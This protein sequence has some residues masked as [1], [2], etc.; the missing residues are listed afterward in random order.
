V[1]RRPGAP[2]H[3][4]TTSWAH[5]EPQ[6]HTGEWR[7]ARSWSGAVTIPGRD[8]R[9]LPRLQRQQ[10]ACPSSP[11]T[12]SRSRCPT[13]DALVKGNEVRIGGVPGRHR[14]VRGA[15]PGERRPRRRRTLAQ[16]RQERRTAAGR[17]D[18]DDPAEVGAGA[19]V[20]AGDA[21]QTPPRALPPAKRSHSPPTRR[22]R[23]TS[24]NS[25]TC[26]DEPTRLAIRQKP[27][28]LRQRPGRSRP[29]S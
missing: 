20:P 14:Q 2:P 10:T 12:T 21:G 7:A 19:E 23:S 25:S 22:N 18:G 24:M 29:R 1:P 16:P 11:P 9:G 3:S 4:S 5:E 17:L 26:F 27:G 8:R 28:R 13:P 6:R 15:G